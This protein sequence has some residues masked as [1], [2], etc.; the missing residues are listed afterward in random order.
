MNNIV[1]EITSLY[2]KYL[3]FVKNKNKYHI[4]LKSKLVDIIDINNYFEYINSKRKKH[5][6]LDKNEYIVKN[7]I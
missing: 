5:I 2:P 6:I 3:I 4:Y 7:M 1:E